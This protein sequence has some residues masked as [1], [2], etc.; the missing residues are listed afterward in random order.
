MAPIVA[1]AEELPLVSCAFDVVVVHQTLHR[2]DLS[3]ALSEMARV[4]RPGGHACVMYLVRDDSVPWVRRFAGIVQ[5]VAPQAMAGDYGHTSVKALLESKYFPTHDHRDFRVWVPMSDAGLR[6]L[7]AGQ[8][9]VAA[10]DPR[11]TA[12]ILDEVHELF[13]DTAGGGGTVRLPYQLKVW[14]AFVDH[15]E[16]TAAI[17]PEYSGFRIRL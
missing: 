7:V 15:D 9:Q 4:L 8:P 12:R 1:R 16:L 3:R 6:A 13:L 5:Q 10:A 11:T 14:R 17:A 2:F